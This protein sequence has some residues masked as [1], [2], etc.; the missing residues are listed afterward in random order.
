[1]EKFSALA[2]IVWQNPETIRKKLESGQA[3]YAANIRFVGVD[4][5]WSVIL[6][7]SDLTHNEQDLSAPDLIKIGFL[8]PEQVN[9]FLKND[10]EFTLSEGPISVFGKGRI[11]SISD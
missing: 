5:L 3:V 2:E 6:L 1:M 8:F 7:L 11:V 4:G 9:R 10:L